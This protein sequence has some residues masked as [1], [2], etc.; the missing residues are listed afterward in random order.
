MLAAPRVA[1]PPSADAGR[2]F[3]GSAIKQPG[4]GSRAGVNAGFNG[5]NCGS[6]TDTQWDFDDGGFCRF[7]VA[8][9]QQF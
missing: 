2:A 4:A 8:V 6:Q 1:L 7:T 3:P 5:G 9:S